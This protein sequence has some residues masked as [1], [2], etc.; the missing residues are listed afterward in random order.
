MVM[1]RG[2][3]NREVEL[4]IWFLPVFLALMFIPM[5]IYLRSSFRNK[6]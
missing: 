1:I 3:L 5:G 6:A 4:G 2:A